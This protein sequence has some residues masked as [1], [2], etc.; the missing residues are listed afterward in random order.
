MKKLTI[1][2]RTI[3][4]R[5]RFTN[6]RYVED[7]QYIV[8]YDG[9]SWTN[10]IRVKFPDGIKVKVPFQTIVTRSKKVVEDFISRLGRKENE[11]ALKEI[12]IN[13]IKED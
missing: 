3:L 10:L 5:T 6:Y 13:I 2:T 11:K 12:L 7:F 8:F 1:Q 9:K 4:K